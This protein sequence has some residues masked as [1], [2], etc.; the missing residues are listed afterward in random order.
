M[1]TVILR[2]V[3]FSRSIIANILARSS[4]VTLNIQLP[5]NGG[6][7]KSRSKR[8]FYVWRVNVTII[9]ALNR[10]SK[11]LR[12]AIIRADKN[13]TVH[14]IYIIQYA[15]LVQYSDLV[16][17][18]LR[19]SGQ[20]LTSDSAGEPL[21]LIGEAVPLPDPGLRVTLC[22]FSPQRHG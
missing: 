15:L 3:E 1:L 6:E 4:D 2:Q 16:W 5:L 18:T 7:F 11:S 13:I 12:L 19:C 21:F 17:L 9:Y 14:L 10:A 20:E 8:A 22:A